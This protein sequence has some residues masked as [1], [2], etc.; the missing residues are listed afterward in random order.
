MTH[1]RQR[2]HIAT[3]S[4]KLNKIRSR[5]NI[6]AQC[7]DAPAPGD[8]SSASDAALNCSHLF[9]MN[10][11]LSSGDYW[12][13]P[14]GPGG[15]APAQVH[16]ELGPQ[17]WMTVANIRDSAADEM[18]NTPNT[19]Y[20]GFRFENGAIHTGPGTVAVS[21]TN[22]WPAAGQFRLQQSSYGRRKSLDRSS[23]T[24]PG[25]TRMSTQS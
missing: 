13:D 18:P 23:E 6:G 19:L 14:D 5:S 10:A 22:T 11:S 7:S 3:G 16:C 15:V 1:D 9:N 24:L 12:V 4:T 25:V 8:G 20:L 21:S 17:A 2:S